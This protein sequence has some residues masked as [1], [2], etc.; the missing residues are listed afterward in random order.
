MTNFSTAQTNNHKI[1]EKANSLEFKEFLVL[2]SIISKNE[3]IRSV[4]S[5]S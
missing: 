1:R 2:I 3:N 4:D 5:G